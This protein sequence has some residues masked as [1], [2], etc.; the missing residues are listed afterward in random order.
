[1]TAI[2]AYLVDR[3]FIGGRYQRRQ[4]HGSPPAQRR[5]AIPPQQASRS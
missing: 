3:Q 1:V 2:T 5:G 4:G